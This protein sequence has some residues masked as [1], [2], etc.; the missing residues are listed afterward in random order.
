MGKAFGALQNE[1]GRI[2]ERFSAG[3]LAYKALFGVQH[4]PGSMGD[5]TQCEA[6]LLDRASLKLETGGDRDQS[7]GVGEAIPDLQITVVA[8]ESFGR[9]L[10]RSDDLIAG[11][12]GVDVRRVAG[13]AVTLG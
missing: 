2:A 1:I 13:K 11:K 6:S 10:D 4:A 8:R 9:Q 3:L 12:V 5:A 7:E